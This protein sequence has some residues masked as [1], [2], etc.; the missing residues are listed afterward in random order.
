MKAL[1]AALLLL[2]APAWADPSA[3]LLPNDAPPAAIDFSSRRQ[4]A[5]VTLAAGVLVTAV[6]TIIAIIIKSNSSGVVFPHTV[7]AGTAEGPVP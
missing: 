2:S 3:R 7:H 4:L 1:L 5:A 6:A